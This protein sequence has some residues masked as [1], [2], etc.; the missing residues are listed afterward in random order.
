M[1]R[2]RRAYVNII[3][4]RYKVTSSDDTKKKTAKKLRKYIQAFSYT[5]N[6]K[7]TLDTISITL[8]NSDFRFCKS[9]FPRKKDSIISSISVYEENKNKKKN[10]LKCGMFV[11]DNP[12]FSGPPNIC[13]IN[14]ICT[15]VNSSFRTAAR[16]KVWK[17]VTLKELAG[18]IAKKY[19]L[20]LEFIGSDVNIGT[21]EQSNENDCD[22]LCSK[23]LDYGYGVKFYR[24]KMI[25]YDVA[26]MESRKPIATI[27]KYQ[28]LDYDWQT[29]IYGTYTGAK[30]RY[31]DDDDKEV[32]CS[33]GK[34]PRWLRITETAD[35]IEQAKKLALAKLNTENEST[36]TMSISLMGNTK[37]I[38][39]ST[40]KIVGFGKLS[41]KYFIDSANHSVDSSAG[42]ITS[43]TLHKVQ[44]RI[45]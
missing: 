18:A 28:L 12:E 7:N 35:S 39:M 5:D 41:G 8:N 38:A 45:G 40:V 11:V 43:L 23:A 42:Y 27:H 33:V 17:K 19:G 24:K 25:I 3:Y 34:E 30:I 9:W 13:C 15:P 14:A 1:A 26:E 20:G 22:F 2:G 21:A 10:L 4:K 37:L 16:N 44:K 32:S 29:N 36:T 6:A 31:S